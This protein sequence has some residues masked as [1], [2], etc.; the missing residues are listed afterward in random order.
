[1][2]ATFP[3]SGVAPVAGDHLATIDWGDGNPPTAG[4][5]ALATDGLTFEV[6]GTHAYAGSGTFPVTVAVAGPGGGVA[7]AVATAT[8]GTPP[9]AVQVTVGGRLAALSDSGVSSEDGITSVRRPTF[10]GEGTPGAS[11]AVLARPLSRAGA[12]LL[13]GETIV[14]ASGRWS[15]TSGIAL[16]D[17]RYAASAR[18]QLGA[19]ESTASLDPPG[20]TL[21]IDTTGPRIARLTARLGSRRLVL[22]VQD[23][24][25]GLEARSLRDPRAYRL[26]GRNGVALP[27][28]VQLGSVPDGAPA[29]SVTLQSLRRNALPRQLL[30]TAGGSIRDLAGN[31]LDGAYLRRFPTGNGRPGTPF[32]VVVANDGSRI[33]G[34]RPL[35]VAAARRGRSSGA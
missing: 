2:V 25:S 33:T 14:D 28:A 27:L 34:I 23:G 18:A 21:V 10:V 4:V 16:A 29:A 6:R 31:G 3:V 32:Q 22:L 19:A 15:V 12:P 24:G 20:R 11:I 8:V 9:P 7:R 13:L 35:A 1:V 5:V 26:A 30:L 17:G